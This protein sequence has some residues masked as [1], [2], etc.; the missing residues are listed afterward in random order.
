MLRTSAE[1][2]FTYRNLAEEW[3]TEHDFFSDPSHLNRYGA[4]AVAN[5]IA[6]DPLIPWAKR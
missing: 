4:F 3:K 6:K 1:L 2:G 5:H